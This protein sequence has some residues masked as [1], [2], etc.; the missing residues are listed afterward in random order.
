MRKIICNFENC[1]EVKKK[2]N[3]YGFYYFFELKKILKCYKV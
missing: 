1:S 2:K 3:Y